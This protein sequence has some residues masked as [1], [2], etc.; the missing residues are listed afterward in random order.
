VPVV[1]PLA[2]IIFAPGDDDP[3]D[4][5][6]KGFNNFAHNDIGLTGFTRFFN[7]L[8]ALPSSSSLNVIVLTMSSRPGIMIYSKLLT[9]LFVFQQNF[10]AGINEEIIWVRLA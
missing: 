8:T 4:T 1:R 9:F 5:D 10:L 6:L 7:T 2:G 3:T